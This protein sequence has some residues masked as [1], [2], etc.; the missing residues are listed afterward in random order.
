MNKTEFVFLFLLFFTIFLGYEYL[1]YKQIELNYYK[2]R[3]SQLDS[4]ASYYYIKYQK[5]KGK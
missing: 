3:T 2:E 5:C 4:A 1:D